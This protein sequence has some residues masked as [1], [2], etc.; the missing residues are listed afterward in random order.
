MYKLR[1]GTRGSKLALWQAQYVA[2]KLNEA[3]PELKVE[4]KVIST[5]GDKILDVALSKIGDKGL[6]TKEIEN[7]LL[8]NEIDIAV[9][10]MK[11]LPTTLSPGLCIGAVLEREKPNDVLISHK[12]YTFKELPLNAILGTSSLRRIA[13]IKAKRPDVICREIRGNVDTRIRKMK[14]QNLDGIVLAYAGV[15]RLGLEDIISDFLAED[16][17]MP[18]VGQGAVAIEI[19]EN[20]E[21]T[22]NVIE[23]ISDTKTVVET[24][25]ERALLKELEGGCQ[26]PIAAYAK[27]INEKLILR[28]KVLSLDG[29]HFFDKEINGNIENSEEIGRTLAQKLVNDG[30]DKILT[31]IKK[32]L[33][34]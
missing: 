34:D 33:G 14:E 11:D 27:V 29:E 26:I 21:A 12:G 32:Q 17:I 6:F 3:I 25:A 18:A 1:V 28:G 8:N 10:S 7:E 23:C 30:A 19:R 5:K 16:I 20:D 9:H 2:E 15:K 31:E 22:K 13:Q 4:V 24:Q